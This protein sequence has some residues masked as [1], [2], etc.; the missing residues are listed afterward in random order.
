[1]CGGKNTLSLNLVRNCWAQRAVVKQIENADYN[2]GR[3][4]QNDDKGQ[5][6]THG[7]SFNNWFNDQNTHQADAS[8]SV[9]VSC[10]HR[11]G[12]SDKN[13]KIGF[14]CFEQEETDRE[15]SL[16]GF[17]VFAG[18]NREYHQS[19]MMRRQ[20]CRNAYPIQVFWHQRRSHPPQQH[21][22]LLTSK[23]DQ[24][25]KYADI[26]NS[27]NK[28]KSSKLTFLITAMRSVAS[29]E[30]ALRKAL[31]KLIVLCFFVVFKKVYFKFNHMTSPSRGKCT[32]QILKD[33]VASLEKKNLVFCSAWRKLSASEE[34]TDQTDAAEDTDYLQLP[35]SFHYGNVPHLT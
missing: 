34:E 11:I 15:V 27:K 7:V 30:I 20:E 35:Y 8:V 19:V 25:R 28:R 18:R 22:P 5:D 16:H 6:K 10:V 13:P 23:G 2:F 4:V 17:P 31:A 9:R 1:M 21:S 26:W 3:I 14:I 33:K 32:K 12:N 24:Q 29:F